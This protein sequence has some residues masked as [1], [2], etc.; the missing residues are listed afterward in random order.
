MQRLRQR[1]IRRLT[2]ARPVTGRIGSRLCSELRIAGVYWGL[3]ANQSPNPHMQPHE[4]R[5]G[6][7]RLAA[8]SE[9]PSLVKHLSVEMLS[10][11]AAAALFLVVL[12]I[13]CLVRA[14]GRGL[15]I[16]IYGHDLMCQ[17]DGGWRVLN[18]QVP[19][20]DF[21]PGFGPLT[22]LVSAAGL[23]LS[24]YEAQGLAY[25]NAM[26]GFAIG[27]WTYAIARRR[28]SPAGALF[29]GWFCALLVLAPFNLGEDFRHLTEAEVYNRYGFALAAIVMIECFGPASRRPGKMPVGVSS[30]AACALLFFLKP[31]YFLVSAAIVF[32]ACVMRA[33]ARRRLFAVSLGFA[34]VAASFLLYLRGGLGAIG[35]DMLL[36]LQARGAGTES[37]LLLPATLAGLFPL[38]M[39]IGVAWLVGLGVPDESAG[40]W[41]G[42]LRAPYR[43][44]ACA[45]I[46]AVAGIL[47]LATNFQK[48]GFPLTAVFAI[49]LGDSMLVHTQFASAPANRDR[50]LFRLALLLLVSLTAAP[51]AVSHA[52]GLAY[53][54]VK[55]Y[56]RD[57]PFTVLFKTEALKKLRM[58][59]PSSAWDG[60]EYATT[61]NDGLDLLMRSSR[62]GESVFCLDFSNPFSYGLQRR[63]APGG[64]LWLYYRENFDDVHQP[65]PE[66]IIGHADLV[67]VPKQPWD[68]DRFEGTWRNY[69][70]FLT[71]H[72]ALAAESSS[73]FMYRRLP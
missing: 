64:S 39:L 48:T 43:Q 8:Q 30:G 24:H 15:P 9:P 67:M 52:A 53:G 7:G 33:H 28:M 44:L 69:G 58:Q 41:R 3:P 37:A 56:R 62:Y 16:L 73:W 49:M 60:A 50:S 5:G 34:I 10:G 29:A 72:F 14:G 11:R 27:L 4:Q 32:W 66:R 35:R 13:A 25:S 55:S 26:M 21:Y 45:G 59:G 17:L 71:R 70:G 54:L 1:L 31:T 36:Q 19:Y 42:W 38:M 22:H 47:L 18:G 40:D 61:V 63:P 6:T 23:S 46:V 2:A 20:I 51:M 12:L 57:P 65:S 68:A